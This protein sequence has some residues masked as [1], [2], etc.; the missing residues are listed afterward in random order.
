MPS[1]VFHNMTDADARAIVVYLRSLQPIA[2]DVSPRQP[3]PIAITAPPLPIA[4]SAIPHTTLAPTDPKAAEALGKLGRDPLWNDSATFAVVVTEF[5]CLC[6][7]A[8]VDSAP[9]WPL[10]PRTTPGV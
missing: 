6:R 3:L 5:A 8:S 9:T 4:E 7:R 2:N 1:Y 10:H